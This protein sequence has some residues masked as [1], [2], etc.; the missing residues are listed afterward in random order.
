MPVLQERGLVQ[1]EYAEGTYREKIYGKGQAQ[2]KDNHPGKSFKHLHE[3]AG[4]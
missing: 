4:N 1:T 3:L 2:L